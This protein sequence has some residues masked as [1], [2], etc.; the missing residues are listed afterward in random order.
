M[1]ARLVIGYTFE[2]GMIQSPLSLVNRDCYKRERERCPDKYGH[3]RALALGAVDRAT[4]MKA[5]SIDLRS[6][7]SWNPLPVLERA[8][9]CV[10]VHT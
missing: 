8:H 3:R 9:R 6:G 4:A 7:K 5:R 2:F 1:H 10:V